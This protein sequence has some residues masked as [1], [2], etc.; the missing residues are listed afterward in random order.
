M[1]SLSWIV[2]H[3]A[4][5]ENFYWV[6]AAQSLRIFPDLHKRVGSGFPASTPPLGEMWST[7]KEIT[8]TADNFLE[9]IS[10]EQLKEHL[11]WK[12]EPLSETTGIL[13][14]RNIYHYW[15]HIGEA[16]AIR[17]MLGHQDLPEFVADM[18]EVDF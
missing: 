15:F 4:S 6:R 3:L 13:L 9:T 8:T 18:S 11:T 12:G 17:D 16:H 5:Q 14:L 2:G 7:W 1:N 10:I